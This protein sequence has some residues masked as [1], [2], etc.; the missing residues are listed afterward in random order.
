MPL[1]NK[2]ACWSL[3]GFLVSVWALSVQADE[4]MFT[5]EQLPDIAAALKDAG[6]RLDPDDLTDLTDFPM[7]AIVSLGGCSGSFV[8]KQGL[9][10]TNHHCAR[11]SIQ[12]NSTEEQNYLADGFY[13]AKLEDE[14]QA[15]PGSRIYVTVD[16][17]DVTDRVTG[18]LGDLSG[19]ARFDAIQNKQKEITAQCE[20][21][22]GHRC[23]VASFFGGLE[24]KLIKRL[25][26][27][28]VR[29]AYAPAD[30]IG[31]YGGDIDNWMWPRH[32][33]DFSFYRAYVAPDGSAADYSEEN[34]PYQPDHVLKVSASGL[35]E[36]DF[37]MVAGYPGSTSRYARLAQVKNVFDWTFPTWITVL[38]R[39]I[40]T[41]E[42]AA[43]TGTD[44]RIK[45]ESRLQGLN[46][47]LK[48]F[49]GQVDGA[50]RVGL[51]ELRA[52]RE[53]ALNAWIADDASRAGYAGAIT[54]LDRLTQE[55]SAAFR[56]NYWFN[57]V[58]RPQLLSAAQRLYRLAHEREKPNAEREP[59]F[60]ERDMA[61]FRQGLQAID[62]R[63]DAAVDKAEWLMFLEGYM[64]QPAEARVAAFDDALGL[65]ARFNRNALGRKL[66]A[67]Y[68]GSS[69]D[70]AA[71]RL[72]L[73]EAD[74]A[75]F[76]SSDD[77]FIAL[78]VA[79]YQTER[80]LEDAAKERSGEISALQPQYM[81]AIVAWQE[82]RG[83]TAYPDA[84]STLRITYGEVLGGSPED[85]LIYEP[86]TRLEGVSAKHTGEEPFDA[87]DA[88]L[89]LIRAEDFGPYEM[90]D[91]GS[92]PVNFLG[93]LDITGGNSGSA[94]LNRRGEMVG[95]VFDGTLESVNSDW[96]F[97]P[98]VIRSIHVDSRY[99]LWVLE[100]IDGADRL[101]DEMEIV[102]RK[103]R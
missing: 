27:R 85:G 18:D 94:T 21:D 38:G 15:A 54:A 81:E 39:W 61:F 53:A 19:R 57:N 22:P 68:D 100:K 86:F 31:R 74:R 87:P 9:V 64:S 69:L 96:H 59:G 35:D 79:L 8:S 41:I 67:Y 90:R 101:L 1:K 98:R 55:G 25:E 6:L 103:R 82:S 56:Q 60:Q 73:M 65:G 62:R 91:I 37:I 32:T 4:G 51:V 95:L 70:D 11:G 28:D 71:T 92:V 72:A 49:K 77:P 50:R 46:N 80:R 47:A 48:N 88:M 5:P 45:Y 102:D 36:G 10:A 99:M 23:Q 89:E 7:G 84:N 83:E 3:A 34:V 17:Q 76:E 26:I 20:E 2:T 75:A 12:Y 16:F 66:D 78:A 58:T 42:D 93:D 13:A 14:L 43:P 29:L 97:D 33:G 40:A 30:M 63:Y 44:A 52:E 24:Y